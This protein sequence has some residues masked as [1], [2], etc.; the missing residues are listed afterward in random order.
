LASG[1]P[2]KL[3]V[4]SGTSGTDISR[5]LG[6]LERELGV[7]T[8]KFEDHV[9]SVFRA[10]I[11][12]VAELLLVGYRQAADR[13]VK[14][15]RE[16]MDE[17]S[18]SDEAVVGAHLVYYRR[19]NVV[20]SPFVKILLDMST[21]RHIAVIDY[22]DDYYHV[23]Y[24]VA[25]RVAEG[26]TPE[27]TGFQVLDPAGLVY[28]RSTHHSV[29]Q[30][31]S[32]HGVETAIYAS[33]HTAVGHARL[34][35]KLLGRRAGDGRGYEAVYVSH[36]IT[37]I[38][39]KALRDGV[40]LNEHPDALDIE[41]FKQTLES[42]CSHLVVYSP[43]AVDELIPGRNGEP[44]ATRIE[45]AVR[46]PHPDNGIHRYVYPVDLASQLFDSTI[47]PVDKTVR[48]KGYMEFLR[49]E[50]EASIERRDLSYVAQADYVVAY[51]PTMYGQQHMGVETEI[52]TAIATAKPVYSV[53][54]PE[55]RTLPYT[56]FRFEYPLT[57]IEE[58]LRVL[59]CT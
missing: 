13:F 25:E 47:Y 32:L 28:W 3:V 35:A 23:L 48:N 50:I 1:W 54:P 30:L 5:V 59:Q 8:A 45:R 14:A 2:S 37:R 27:V 12:H 44:L 18:G 46:W 11:Y 42:R 22:V 20:I 9:E 31:L 51:R 33:K 53:V 6:Y 19:S 24:R 43:T 34:V 49:A 52:K 36:P 26:K 21:E 58:L 7:A 56:L 57:N 16:M 17:L 10:P 55:E 15:Y 40:P 41:R 4:I 39:E 38:R 29:T